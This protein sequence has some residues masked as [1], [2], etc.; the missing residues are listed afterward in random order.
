M[1]V[2]N[3]IFMTHIKYSTVIPV[4]NEGSNIR[5]LYERLKPVMDRCSGPYEIIF[6]D[7]GSSDNSYEL[8]KDI[9]LSDSRVRV[10]S[11]TH[12]FGQHNAVVAGIL[13]SKG[14]FIVTMD[15]DLQNPP[16]EV[17]KLLKEM[18]KGFDMVS[19]YRK[20]RKDTLSRKLC[21]RLANIII[22]ARTGV[23]LRDYG[24][25]L[26][27]FTRDCAIRLAEEFRKSRG[28]ITMLAAKVAQNIKEVEVC[29]EERYSGTSKYGIKR[30]FDAFSRAIFCKSGTGHKDSKSPIFIIGRIIE[31]RKESSVNL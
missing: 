12:N 1:T 7:D 6:V 20:M 22:S 18:E 4:F 17:L 5:P 8:L 15:A 16:E 11:F 21:S 27:V 24:S 23:W 26:R 31:D 10:I 25:M 28:Y 29:H 14:E 3:E 9:A 19:G 2:R 30:L 13:K